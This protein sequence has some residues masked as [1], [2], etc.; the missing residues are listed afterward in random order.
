MS[1]DGNTYAGQ[2]TREEEAKP[3]RRSINDR[4]ESA[5][6]NVAGHD[7]AISH[8]MARLAQLEERVG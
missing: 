2:L 7:E 8:L 4:L 6:A 5:E 1:F 3:R